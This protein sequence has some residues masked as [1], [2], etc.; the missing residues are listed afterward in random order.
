MSEQPASPL[1]VLFLCTHNSARSQMAEG[2]LR[3]R[4]G[5]SFLVFSAGTEPGTVH[6]LAIKVMQEIGIDLHNHTAKGI[7]TFATQ[8][9]M[10]LVITVCHE[11]QVACPIFPNAR[12]QVHWGFSDPSRVTGT[13]EE[14]LAAFRHIRDLIAARIAQLLE[15]KPVLSLE[16]LYA[17]AREAGS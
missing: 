5:P 4:G 2:L 3:A 13:E 12:R 16:Q 10:D 1:R 11:A 15:H 14:R 8:P 17:A 6:P 7:A 9:P